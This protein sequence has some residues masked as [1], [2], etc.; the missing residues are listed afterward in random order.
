MLQISKESTAIRQKHYSS[1]S[2][3]RQG[4][5]SGQFENNPNY[6]SMAIRDN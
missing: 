2:P 6:S 4:L 5:N 1:R 3:L